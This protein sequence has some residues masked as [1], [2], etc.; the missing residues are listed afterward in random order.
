MKTKGFTLI[1]MIL[2]LSL[3]A[4]LFT[5]SAILLSQGVVSFATISE[6]GS[7]LQESRF[8]MERMAREII[9]LKAGAGGD[10]QNI[11]PTQ[12]SFIDKSALN[13]DFHLD[14]PTQILYRG[15]NPLLE[16]VTA[17]TYTAF[18]DDNAVTQST[19]QT[20]RIQIALTILPKGETA[21]LILRTNIFLRT[22]LYEKFK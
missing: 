6:R 11:L 15:A 18:R 8:A 1:E 19:P 12:I 14:A 7:S 10:L 2:T 5:L 17:L 4:I 21:P 13:T 3:V 22:D 9:L 16:R 20:R